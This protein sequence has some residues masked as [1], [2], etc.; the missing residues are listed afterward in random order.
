MTMLKKQIGQLL[1][2]SFAALACASAGAQ[3]SSLGV[4][5]WAAT[6]T[7]NLGGTGTTGGHGAAAA[8]I[9][10]VSTRAGLIQAL[11]GNT[12]TIKTNGTFTGTLDT[13]SYTHLTLP[14]KRIV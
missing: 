7:N 5:G 12:A 10:T 14:T 3:I 4:T 8:K 9:Y 13:V 11:Y 1:C 6:G 2:A